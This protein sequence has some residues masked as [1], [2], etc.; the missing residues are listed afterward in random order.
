MMVW[1]GYLEKDLKEIGMPDLNRRQLEEEFNMDRVDNQPIT[2]LPLDDKEDPD[3]IIRANIE[4]ANRILDQVEDEML[5][6]N[7]SAR[8]VEVAA[9]CMDTITNAV[10]QI[11]STGY[12]SD[13]L[14]LKNR[15]VELKEN[16]LQYKIKNLDKPQQKI[17]SQN[18]IFTDRE[19]L[20]KALNNKKLE[21]GE[22]QDE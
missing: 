16:E 14:Q 18:I 13:Y 12:N 8:L 1:N 11:Q 19:S 2:L 3:E 4:R 6:G 17:G 22:N 21:E 9:K 20:L 10:S 5:N 7:F 15:M